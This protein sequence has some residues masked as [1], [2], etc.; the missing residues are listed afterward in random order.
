MSMPSDLVAGFRRH[1]RGKRYLVSARG[2]PYF[3]TNSL[4]EAKQHLRK[5]TRKPA[6]GG[7]GIIEDRD[8]IVVEFLGGRDAT[9]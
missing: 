1:A 4:R 5:I 3:A 6:S 9:R 8:G 7:N 2:S